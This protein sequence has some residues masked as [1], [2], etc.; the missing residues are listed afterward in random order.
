SEQ[1]AFAFANQVAIA[2]AN[3]DLYTESQYRTERLSLLN[4]VSVALAQSLDSENILEVALQ[5][6]AGTMGVPQARAL[7]FD[8]DLNIGRVI[9]AYP[10]GDAP[11]DEIVNLNESPTHE[12]LRR[13]VSPLVI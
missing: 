5:E 9:V 8:R 12:L 11:P 6:I 3:A 10:R 1:A 2:L 13:E 4:R 7:V